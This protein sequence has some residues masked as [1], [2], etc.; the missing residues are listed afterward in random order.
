MK[1]ERRNY[2]IAPVNRS[3]LL[4]NINKCYKSNDAPGQVLI[5]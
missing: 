5:T 2:L 3:R 1:I 4:G